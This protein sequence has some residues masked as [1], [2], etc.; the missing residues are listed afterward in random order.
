MRRIRDASLFRRSE[1]DECSRTR[2]ETEGDAKDR[3][4]DPTN[5][6]VDREAVVGRA[7]GRV[8]VEL[9]RVIALRVEPNET[10]EDTLRELR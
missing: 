7:A 4:A 3:R 10:R 6:V 2:I 9:D 1:K 8:D 5:H